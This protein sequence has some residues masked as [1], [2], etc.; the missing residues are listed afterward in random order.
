[1]SFLLRS[2]SLLKSLSTVPRFQFTRPFSVSSSLFGELSPELNKKIEGLT[3]KSD[4]VLFMKGTPEQPLCGFSK[5]A[6]M[7]RLIMNLYTYLYF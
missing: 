7:V 4:V 2:G 3:K 1:M 5:T 6:K